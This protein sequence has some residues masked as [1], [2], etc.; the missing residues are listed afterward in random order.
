[1]I[2]VQPTGTAQCTVRRAAPEDRER[3]LRMYATFEPKAAALGLPPVDPQRCGAW[4]DTLAGGANFVAMHAS[5]VVGHAVLYPDGDSGEVAVFV[6]QDWRGCGFGRQLLTA[7]VQHARAIGLKRVWGIA[8]PDNVPMLRLAG[9][10][11][12]TETFSG[13]FYANLLP[14][15]ELRNPL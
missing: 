15:F 5:D 11:G 8:E 12:F 6:H 1:M 10:C 3:L 14:Q 4:L 9:T 7:L 2:A 13:E